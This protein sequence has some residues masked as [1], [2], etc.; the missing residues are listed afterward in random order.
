MTV[1]F[2]PP[3]RGL[4]LD[5]DGVL[6]RANQPI[7]SLEVIF[8]RINNLGYHFILATNNAT[9]SPQMYQ[10]K[11]ASFNVK[12]ELDQ[13]INSAMA[14]TF[15]LC[16]KFPSGGPV[17]IIGET[18]LEK[19]L[20]HSGFY[21]QDDGNVLA[22]VA[23][24]DRKI[25]YQKLSHATLLIRAGIPFFGTN[26]DRTYPSPEGLTPGAGSILAAIQAA[27]DVTPLI[28]GKPGRFMFDLALERLGTLP[29]ETLSIGDRLDTDIL[30]AQQ[31]GCRTGLVLSGIT[32][33]AEASA[34]NPPPDLICD[35]LTALVSQLVPVM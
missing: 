12:V 3:L 29:E 26:P 23:G 4:I 34:W 8:E 13:V 35:D 11:L 30:G 6:W 14:V 22:V 10:E 18:G 32:T 7:G 20:N 19:V 5:M 28:G 1:S 33:P 24:L 9:L 31:V 27:T 16:Q 17:Y 2:T 15:A 21:R 25:T